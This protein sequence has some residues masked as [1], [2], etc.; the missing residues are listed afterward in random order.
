MRKFLLVGLLAAV[1]AVPAMA[2]LTHGD[3]STAP[4]YQAEIVAPLGDVGQR[5][6]PFVYDSLYSGTAGYWLFSPAV[7]PLGY[8]DYDTISSGVLLSQVKFVGGMTAP[9]GIMWFEFYTNFTS[10]TFITSFGVHIP[11]SGWWIW[12]INMG[13]P[14]L[15]PH[16]GLM[17]IAANS[18]YTPFPM[19]IAG[20]W[21]WTS[22]DAVVAGSN[23]LGYGTPPA[24]FTTTGGVYS[25]VNAFA[26]VIPEPAT[27]AL[28][29]AGLLLVV[30][31]R[32]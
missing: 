21:F 1:M 29:G 26:F 19:D 5:C 7:G 10:P 13:S 6:G 23:M 24:T 8:D 4:V 31:R 22:S 16:T 2:E 3:R 12:T 25:M 9:S 27:L 20:A 18:T 28:F 32:R 17:Q 15:I 14:F 11:Q 30:R